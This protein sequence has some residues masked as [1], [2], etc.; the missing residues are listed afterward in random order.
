VMGYSKGGNVDPDDVISIGIVVAVVGGIILLNICFFCCKKGRRCCRRG[1]ITTTSSPASS[2]TSSQPMV[3]VT[4][5]VASTP[6]PPAKQPQPASSMQYE[7]EVEMQSV[8]VTG[9]S[10]PQYNPYQPGSPYPPPPPPTTSGP[11][12]VGEMPPGPVPYAAAP[13]P[14]P[15][16][17]T[18]PPSSAAD[19]HHS[20]SVNVGPY[21]P[22]EMN[23]YRHPPSDEIQGGTAPPLENCDEFNKPASAVSE[24]PI[25]ANP[26]ADSSPAQ[27][28]F[29]YTAAPCSDPYLDNVVP[30]TTTS[31]NN[32]ASKYSA[33]PS[34]DPY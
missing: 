34:S 32:F 14:P 30:T 11:Y 17:T 25:L 27:P 9:N 20:S 13:P 2:T 15:P 28:T 12:P 10:A 24:N 7:N 26:Y 6:P 22:S 16:T 1:R 19:L 8:F 3:V 33:P 29:S 4:P 18:T 23:N 21:P 31:T 5:V